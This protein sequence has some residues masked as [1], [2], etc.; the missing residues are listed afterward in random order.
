MSRKD[1][2]YY[3]GTLPAPRN[4]WYV[5]AFSHEVDEKPMSRRI[6]GDRIVFYRTEAG[7]PVALSD[8]CPHRAVALSHGKRVA[9]DRIQ[10]VYH[11]IEFGPDGICRKVPSQNAVP[12]RMATRA[13]P[14]AERWR[15]IWI[16]MGDPSLADPDLIPDHSMFGLGESDGFHKVARFR[17]DIGGSYQLLH[18]NLLDVSH[19]SFL[20]EGMFDTGAIAQTPATTEVEGNV[21]TMTRRLDETARG[22][23]ARIFGLED[24]IRVRRQLIA[25]TY[26]P[27]LNVNTNV[28]EFP[29]EPSRPAY[30]RHAP[31]AITPETDRSCH[32]F[33]ASAGNYGEAATGAALDAQNQDVWNI[34]LTDKLAIESIQESYDE[35]GAAAPDAS[36]KA[37]DAAV[38]FRRMI[39][40]MVREEQQ[41]TSERPLLATG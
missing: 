16:W 27:A 14:L 39:M 8:Y 17:M 30:I 23:Y 18:E 35:M 2:I 22:N 28:F 24:G 9:G 20:H 6:L 37:D 11:G 12:R 21:I 41:Q 25:K 40:Q 29:D 33:A 1:E 36:V 15:W 31:F 3:P 4:A 26:I 5:C 7:D 34:F 10:C 13:Y 38:R 32:Y 19:I